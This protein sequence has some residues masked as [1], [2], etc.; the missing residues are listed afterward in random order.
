[1]NNVTIREDNYGNITNIGLKKIKFSPV[2]LNAVKESGNLRKPIINKERIE[3]NRPTTILKT[4]VVDE[5]TVVVESQT[6]EAP[7][8]DK[9]VEEVAPVVEAPIE[10]KVDAPSFYSGNFQP[11]YNFADIEQKAKEVAKSYREEPK[12]EPKTAEVK[13]EKVITVNQFKELLATS[14]TTSVAKEELAKYKNKFTELTTALNDL[15]TKQAKLADAFQTASNE[16]QTSKTNNEFIERRTKEMRNKDNFR[17]LE[18]SQN[19]DPR[20]IEIMEKTNKDLTDLLNMNLKVYNETKEKISKFVND[21]IILEKESS[22][23]REE[24]QNK[25]NEL[26]A[27]MIEAAT[28]IRKVIDADRMFSESK[29]A[30]QKYNVVS[31]NTENLEEVRQTISAN[32]TVD[33]PRVNP[34]VSQEQNAFD[35]FR[36]DNGERQSVMMIHN[37]A[38]FQNGP[39]SYSGRV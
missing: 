25:T 30:G 11:T 7:I 26:N 35:R 17:Y 38:E 24:I 28:I 36:E 1:M 10:E 37:P 6:F 21:K 39:M 2:Q 3:V 5:P 34:E 32:N 18:V 8:Q 20:I 27:F 22:K 16:E 23:V 9:V 29:E 13:E 14:V 19:E 31:N 33:I 15:K 4:N 12:E